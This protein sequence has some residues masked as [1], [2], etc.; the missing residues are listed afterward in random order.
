MEGER[1][2]GFGVVS[3]TVRGNE[4]FVSHENERGAQGSAREVAAFPRNPPQ[5][6]E[7]PRP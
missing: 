6:V 1:G 7:Y 4:D 3:G 2:A 5:Y